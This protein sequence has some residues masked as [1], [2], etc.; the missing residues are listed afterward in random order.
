MRDLGLELEQHLQGALRHLG[1]VRRIGRQ[2]LGP[3]DHVVDRCRHVVAVGAG[4]DEERAIA[5]RHVL[6]RQGAHMRLDQ[7]LWRV[8]RQVYR[9]VQQRLCGHTGKQ[10]LGAGSADHGEH[11]RPLGFGMGEVAH[12]YFVRSA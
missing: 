10:I 7:E 2:P 9:L 3:L 8:F 1:L 11:L 12:G 5:C 4:A 6:S